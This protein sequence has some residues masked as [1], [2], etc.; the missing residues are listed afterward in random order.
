MRNYQRI[1]QCWPASFDFC[2]RYR[3]FYI[4]TVEPLSQSALQGKKVAS[5][6]NGIINTMLARWPTAISATDS[7][8]AGVLPTPARPCGYPPYVCIARTELSPHN[9]KGSKQTLDYDRL[10]DPEPDKLPGLPLR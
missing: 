6:P 9:Q 3:P 4:L 8:P 1:P 10:K 7:F 5:F 2:E